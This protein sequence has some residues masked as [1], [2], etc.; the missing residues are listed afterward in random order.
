MDWSRDWHPVVRLPLAPAVLDLSSSPPD[1]G[2]DDATWTVGRYD[3]DRRAVYEQALFAGQRTVHMG[4]DIGGPVGTPVHACWDGVVESA[5]D[6]TEDGDYGPTVVLR[7]ELEQTLW[8]LHGHLQR[9]S[10]EGLR[11][12]GVVR[13]GEIIGWFGAESENGGWPP[14]LHFQLSFEPP[15]AGDIPGVVSVQERAAAR[16]RFPDPR[17]VLGPLY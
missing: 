17:L 3:E 1:W 9:R 12:G 4:I 6:L 15:C 7:H 16:A 11:P 8:T 2:P 10:L 5:V 14:H 13:R